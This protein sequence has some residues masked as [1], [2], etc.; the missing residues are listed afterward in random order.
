LKKESY[1]SGSL[2]KFFNL[3]LPAILSFMAMSFQEQI[4]VVFV[5]SSTS[6]AQL[7]AIGIGNMF[8]NLFPYAVMIGSNSALE[9]LVAQ[10]YGRKNLHECGLLLHKAI[11]FMSFTFVPVCFSAIYLA[12][13]LTGLGID[14]EV[15]FYAQSYI[16]VLLPGMLMNSIGDAIDLFLIAMGFS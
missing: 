10:A 9:T 2:R 4:N 16:R 3:A 5:G 15:A 11:L 14:A 7:A 13:I 1:V 12:K 6:T 8:L